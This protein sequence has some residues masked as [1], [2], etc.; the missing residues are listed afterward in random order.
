MRIPQTTLLLPALAVGVNKPQMKIIG[1]QIG[2]MADLGFMAIVLNCQSSTDV[3]SCYA[4]CS[5]SLIAPNVV[6]TAAHCVRPAFTHYGDT[7]TDPPARL[8]KVALG[9]SNAISLDPNSQVIDVSQVVFSSFGT[10]IRFSFDGDVALLELAQ[11]V[12]ESPGLIEYAK[13]ATWETEPS[14]SGCVNIT[15]A[16][17]GMVSNVPSPLNQDDGKLRYITDKLLSPSVCRAAYAALQEGYE[18][19]TVLDLSSLSSDVSDFVLGD[20]FICS[21]GASRQSV[22]YGDSGG[23]SFTRLES[24]KAQVI[25]TTS[26]GYGD[27]YCT[28][29]P[30]FNTRTA[31]HA[32]WIR[33]QL[34]TKIYTCP[35]WSVENSFASSARYPESSLSADWTQSRCS[36]GQWQCLSGECISTS[37]VCDGMPQCSDRSD[38]SYT[39]D[40]TSLC[41]SSR[42]LSSVAM[43]SRRIIRKFGRTESGTVSH[44]SLSSSVVACSTAISLVDNAVAQVSSS[45]TT[46]GDLYWN[47]SDLLTACD[48]LYNCD[49][50]GSFN[51]DSYTT[52]KTTCDA[53]NKWYDW[54]MK[55]DQYSSSF[56]QVY[57]A[58]CPDDEY[59]N[60]QTDAPIEVPLSSSSTRAS[61]TDSS[62]SSSIPALFAL[63]IGAL[64]I[65]FNW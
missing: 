39:Y 37:Q 43:A 1:G 57:G 14:R 11:C 46:I 22:C 50:N 52:D 31:F 13:V 36:V 61:T 32:D 30:D 65:I 35:N 60:G 64:T 16:G 56:G 6:L 53:I 18:V 21:G 24:G 7:S 34:T 49:T 62:S 41:P 8:L 47:P 20:N 5:G 33:E 29:G 51:S 25:A 9:S 12:D 40:G 17:Y 44:I 3:S 54:T 42:R 58:T 26:F 28:L 38:E 19:P 27:N 10:N 2:S 48:L 45:E 4:M 15:V 63:G 59:I 55:N 23:P